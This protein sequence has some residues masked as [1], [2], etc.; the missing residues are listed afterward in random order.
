MKFASIL[1]VAAMCISASSAIA[2]NFG[3]G[4]NQRLVESRK[5]QGQSTQWVYLNRPSDYQGPGYLAECQ[6]VSTYMGGPKSNMWRTYYVCR[7][8]Y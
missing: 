2:A 1:L 7:V 4:Y 8:A 6:K 5:N 3:E